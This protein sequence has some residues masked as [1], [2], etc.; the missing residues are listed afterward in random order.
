M[1]KHSPN[2]RCLNVRCGALLVTGA[3]ALTGCG[4]A[5]AKI[6]A[7]G[8]AST[9]AT[10]YAPAARGGGIHL[11]VYS[12]NSDGAY[13][14]SVV[15]GAIGDYGPAVTVYP[16][17]KVDPGHTSEL[18][19]KLA[20]GSFRLTIKAADRAFV[21][22]ASHEPIYPRTCSDFISVTAPAPVVTGSGTGSYRG[23]R[24]T[25]RLTVTLTEVEAST[26]RAGAPAAFRS[27]V[28]ALTGAGTIAY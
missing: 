19:L 17:G 10:A 6:T 4:S 11:L 28:I 12:V 23:I 25:L 2:A 21:S 22:A 9:H 3:L 20:H 7:A 18:E 24:G 26:C 27:Q 1:R 15:T 14:R 5:A 13:F 8:G 16:S